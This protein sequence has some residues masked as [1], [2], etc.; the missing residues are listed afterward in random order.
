MV[1]SEHKYFFSFC[2]FNSARTTP[3]PSIHELSRL[4]DQ[5]SETSVPAPKKRPPQAEALKPQSLS[6]P[7]QGPTF[8]KRLYNFVSR[9]ENGE[10]EP[11]KP[12]QPRRPNP[13]QM[14]KMGKKAVVIA[15][16][17]AGTISF[18]RFGQGTF[19]EWPMV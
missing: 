9:S 12:L 13:F 6:I 10:A 15:A 19:D 3:M 14:L 8:W 16:V 11:L 5:L 2:M 7:R 4:F 18:F 1:I 17:D